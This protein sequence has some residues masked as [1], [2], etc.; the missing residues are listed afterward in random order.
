MNDSR[1]LIVLD[2]RVGEGGGQIL[3]TGLA[4]SAITGA[5]VEIFNIRAGRSKPGLAAQHL[6][7]VR[8]VAAA[9]NGRLD[10][11]FLG[12][13]RV[14]MS[15]GQIR[16][17]E[18]EL[19]IAAERPS[20][21]AVTLVMQALLPVLA[22]ADGPSRVLLHGGTHVEWSPSF[23]YLDQVLKP[24]LAAVGVH[25]KVHLR[26]W[27]WYPQGGGAIGVDVAGRAEMYGVDWTERGPIRAI[28]GVSVVSDLP[29]DIAE[30]QAQTARDML[31]AALPEVPID[32]A[33]ESIESAGRGSFFF[34]R[35][36]YGGRGGSENGMDGGSGVVDGSGV[37]DGS[38]VHDGNLPQAPPAGF[39]ALGRRGKRAET[40]G[41]EAT[42]ALLSHHR[43]G[44]AL[45]DHLADQ[46]LPF[47]ALASG[48][49]RYT[50]PRIS[51]HL[52]TNAWVCERLLDIRAGLHEDLPCTVE[53]HGTG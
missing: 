7:G 26:S 12:S 30:R 10:G 9:C 4:L 35:A 53:I 5:P 23:H 25:F 22:L 17:G 48:T 18:Y 14:A 41:R 11:D 31:A 39:S 2:G 34:L 49:S 36:E 51:G 15:P 32:I 45:D 16:A 28:S 8:A 19:D 6:T 40:V 43:S 27:G 21:G 33:E 29:F 1:Q 13:D 47:L 38:G 37:D 52:R 42:E 46:V 20:A 3:R 50:S 44:A 24:T